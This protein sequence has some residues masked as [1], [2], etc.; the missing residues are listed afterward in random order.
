MLGGI[1][2]ELDPKIRKG[3]KSTRGWSPE[4]AWGSIYDR[5]PTAQP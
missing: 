1:F 4:K 3:S 5:D 2:L